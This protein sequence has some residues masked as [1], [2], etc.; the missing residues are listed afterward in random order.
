MPIH[1]P[2]YFLPKKLE[3][4]FLPPIEAGTDTETLKQRVYETMLNYYESRK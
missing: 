3:I 2:F 4:H 1:K